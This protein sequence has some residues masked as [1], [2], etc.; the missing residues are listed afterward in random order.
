MNKKIIFRVDAAKLTAI[1]TGGLYRSIF[2]AKLLKKKYNLKR[3]NLIFLSKIENEFSVAKKILVQNKIKYQKINYN[4]LDYSNEEHAEIIKHRSDMLVIDKYMRKIP[5]KFIID[6]K[7]KYKKIILIDDVSKFRNIADLSLNP[8]SYKVPKLKNQ[9]KGFQYN[10]LPSYN[11]IKK[12]IINDKINSFSIFIFFGGYDKK[13][14]TLKVIKKLIPLNK[15]IKFFVNESY[16]I[17]L[18]KKYIKQINFFNYRDHYKKLYLSNLSINNG[19]LGMM[20]A[21]LFKKPTICIPQYKHQMINIK[22]LQ[23]AKVIYEG[24]IKEFDKVI[25]IIKKIKDKKISLSKL[26]FRQN[27]IISLNS[28][29]RTLKLIF[30]TYEK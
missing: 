14:L 28:I 13:K 9:K 16:K 6:L 21:I 1:G 2:L 10:L 12:K 26:K 4:T 8:M 17:Y 7:K 20:D 30:K 11:F 18:S 23:K 22:K 27:N 19:G 24:K 3:D 29:S 15:G 25:K 5:K